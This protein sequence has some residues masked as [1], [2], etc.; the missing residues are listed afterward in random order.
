VY[1][2]TKNSNLDEGFKINPGFAILV[3]AMIIIGLLSLRNR[4]RQPESKL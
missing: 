3:V 4:K 2:V 1:Q